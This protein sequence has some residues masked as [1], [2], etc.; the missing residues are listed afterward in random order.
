MR[1]RGKHV[2]GFFLGEKEGG[3]G[4][5]DED[6][7]VLVLFAS[8]AAAVIANARTHRDEQRARA[9]LEALVETSPV[10]V[11]V[12]DAATANPLSVNREAKRIL[13][14]LLSSDG[15]LE[16]LPEVL[17]ARRADGREVTLDELK[18]A[19]TLR[20]EEVELSV[21]DGRS[22]RMLINVTPIRLGDGEIES[23]MVT[24]QDLAPLE[25]LER[26]RVEFLGM[27]SHELRAP[28]TSIKGSTTTTLLNAP[29]ALDRAEMRQFIRIIDQQADRMQ[30]LIGDLLD[31]GRINAGTLSVDPEPLEVASLVEQARTTFLSCGGR[32]SLRIDLP[33]ELPRV[34]ADEERIV[35][36]LNNLF[37]NAARRSPESSPIE[38]GAVRDG[39]EVAVSVTDEG[40]GVAPEQLGHLFRRY[41]DIAGRDR[42]AAGFGLGLVIC[43]GLVEAH[44]GAHPGRERGFGS[45]HPDHLHAPDSR[46]GRRRRGLRCVRERIAY[47]PRGP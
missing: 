9:D 16:N 7:E 28:L 18:S 12:L 45:R 5:T 35:Q 37:S 36:V 33:A 40:R 20:A 6:E 3:G 32:Q 27:V 43:K 31:A 38:V 39:I 17:T 25:E 34:M 26:L 23:V 30:G 46:A 21:P 42:R 44:G 29:R 2:G 8:Q 11:V 15:T 1:H 10:G 22:V 13:G 19:E 41:S 14:R 4:F 47:A 24:L